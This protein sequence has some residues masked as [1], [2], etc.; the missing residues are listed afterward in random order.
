VLT[1]VELKSL[2]PR[3]KVY[4]RADEK[5]LYIRVAPT[6]AKYWRL[7]YYMGDGKERHLA[8]GVYPEVPL[9]EAREQREDARHLIRS[10]IDPS[11]DRKRKNAARKFD[12]ENSFGHIADQWYSKNSKK[13]GVSHRTR[14]ERILNKDLAGIRTQPITAIDAPELLK[15]LRRIESRGALE[16]A[17]RA[18]QIISQVY[19]FAIAAGLPVHDIAR[20]LVDALEAPIRQHRAAITD[21]KKVGPLLRDLWGYQGAE[22]MRAALK[23]APLTFVRPGELR[24]MEWTEIDFEDALWTIPKE[25]MKSVN[26]KNPRDH[27]IPLATQSLDILRELQE[28]TGEYRWA[29]PSG[30]TVQR[31]MSDNGV[32]SALRTLGIPKV[33]MSGHGF[34]AMARTLLDEELEFPSDWIEMQLAHVLKDPNGQAYNR[35]KYLKQRRDM[36]QRWADYLDQLRDPKVAVLRPSRENS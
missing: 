8:L 15:Q 2:E 25:K 31:P 24:R 10:G 4:K 3:E 17:R 12:A 6:G 32:L 33:T 18:R 27:M 5:G 1:E 20:D 11:E 7:K 21:W 9:K 16:T 19:R 34:R 36:M 29:F 14:T 30:R 23:L 28:V 22:P 35:S 26:T 13:W